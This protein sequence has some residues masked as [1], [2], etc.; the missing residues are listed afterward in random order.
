MLYVYV[1]AILLLHD[2]HKT[3]MYFSLFKLR[4]NNKE[5]QMYCIVCCG[6][7]FPQVE[8]YRFVN[9]LFFTLKIFCHYFV[10]CKLT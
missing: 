1:G 10:M 8:R 4:F 5:M 2:L 9:Y 6:E 7:D 3:D